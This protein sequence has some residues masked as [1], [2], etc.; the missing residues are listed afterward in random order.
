[1]ADLE[2]NVNPSGAVEGSLKTE[3]ALGGVKKKARETEQ[4][5]DNLGNRSKRHLSKTEQAAS[6]AGKKMKILV[7]AAATAAVAFAGK[8][9]RA[10]VDY[11][12]GLAEVSTL[13]EGTEQEMNFLDKSAKNLASTFGGTATQQ[14]NAF[15]QAISAGAGNV[16]QANKLLETANKLA[17]GG[18]TDIT[19]SVDALTTATNAYKSFGLTAAQASDILFTGVKK[20]KTTVAELGSALGQIVP[21]SAS[22]GI[23]FSEVVSAIAALTTSGQSTAQAVTGTRQAMVSVLKPTS[24]A[25]KLAKALGLEF[26]TSALKAKGFAGFL[27]DVK[28]K[29]GGSQDAMAK[30]FGS[31]E[32]LNAVLALSGDAG[33]VMAETMKE[34]QTASG[35]T[36]EAFG[37]VSKSLSQRLSVQLGIL[38]SKALELGEVILSALVPA[39]EFLTGRTN[40]FANAMIGVGAVVTV[41][42]PL[43]GAV[44]LLGGLILKVGA[45]WDYFKASGTVALQTIS[46][47]TGLS[48][49]DM[50]KSWETLKSVFGTLW[51]TFISQTKGAINLA[52]GL[53][54]SAFVVFTELF[55]QLP[56]VVGSAI[57]GATNSV[58]GAIESMVNKAVKGINSLSSSINS[59]IS[60][61]GADKAAQFFGF[62]G[63]LPQIGNVAL[64]RFQNDFE[65]T[66]KKTSDIIK[67]A[68][69]KVGQD[70][71]GSFIGNFK[72]KVVNE[73]AKSGLIGKGAIVP[74]STSPQSDA[75]SQIVPIKPTLDPSDFGGGSGGGS[76]GGAAKS[77]K[78]GIDKL[79]SAYDALKRSI[80][81]AYAA[82]QDFAKSQDVVEQALANGLI[83]KSEAANALKILKKDYDELLMKQVKGADKASSFFTRIVTGA[84][85]ATQAVADLGNRM[86]EKLLNQ[87]FEMIL[88][89][90]F[91]GGGFG[92]TLLDFIFN[93]KGNAFSSGSVM[94]FAS[95]GVVD[96]A[97]PFGMSNGR[98]GVM[99]E[100]GPEAIL[101]LSRGSDGKLGVKAKQQHGQSINKVEFNYVIDARGTNN[102][103][104]QNLEMQLNKHKAETPSLVIKTIRASE[105]QRITKK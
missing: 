42:F 26:T 8:S 12:K 80:D 51:E 39:L 74:G 56:I 99:G 13:I 92:S 1:M 60:F 55:P 71:V 62:S 89:S 46:D 48:V 35:A 98:M 103:A 37:K 28:E 3:Q 49:Q 7:A 22:V 4:E 38:G 47:F 6:A 34:M 90:L 65:G 72:A 17:V 52:I 96:R 5:L 33:K 78:N 18:V 31:V 45:N 66:L 100:K 83:T 79:A 27:K 86:A 44:T 15:Y 41:F 24:E 20:G 102:E 85:S 81:P 104:V 73:L 64:G 95:G 94:A 88:G 30:L 67:K 14:M 105:K 32:A 87:G 97:T 58:I 11:S 21:T 84:K 54:N 50:K 29:T 93:A 53:A 10:Y 36:E 43:I 77:A 2:L 59:I 16:E 40:E 75:T 69:S 82:S 101:P 76:G 25:Q 57:V 9:T 61:L 70:Y 19:T 68:G 91:G 23:E 63:Q